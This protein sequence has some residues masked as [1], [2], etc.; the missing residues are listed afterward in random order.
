MLGTLVLAPL[1]LMAIFR[2]GAGEARQWL[3]VEREAHRALLDTLSAGRFPDDPDGRR[4]A[5][6]RRP[7]RR[8][9]PAS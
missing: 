5:A 6:L 9:G 2:F 3:A 4:I 8:A 7:L 1:A